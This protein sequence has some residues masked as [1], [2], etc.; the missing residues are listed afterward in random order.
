MLKLKYFG[1]IVMYKINDNIIYGSHGICSIVDITE[2]KFNFETK[3]YYV[4][5][6]HNNCSSSIYVPVDNEKLISKMRRILSKE[7]ISE[8][9]KVMPDA[10]DEWIENKNERN[11]QFR[12]I[13]SSGNRYDIIKL[14]KTIYKHNEYL[15]TI[16]KKPHSSDMQFFKEAE[17]LIYEEFAL[18][19]NIKYDQV[20]PF[21][22]NN[23]D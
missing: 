15:K 19:L 13:L 1:G 4:L 21:I 7:E 20:L 17:K 2:Q 9:I 5:R 8:L 18:V 3:T 16:G 6:P 14:I 11:E 10:N 23:I 22:M 12:S